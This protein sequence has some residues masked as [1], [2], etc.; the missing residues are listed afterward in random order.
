[1]ARLLER[2]ITVLSIL[3]SEACCFRAGKK[4][5]KEKSSYKLES[6]P[7]VRAFTVNY[8]HTKQA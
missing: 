6:Y 4:N 8:G 2:E 3:S 5:A 7:G 1:M